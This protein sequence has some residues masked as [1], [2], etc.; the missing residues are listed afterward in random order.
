M[1]FEFFSD[2]IFLEFS[3]L[4]YYLRGPKSKCFDLFSMIFD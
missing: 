4:T 1:F 2:T 3:F